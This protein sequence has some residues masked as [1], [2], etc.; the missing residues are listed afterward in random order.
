MAGIGVLRHLLVEGEDEVET[1]Y[2]FYPELWGRGYAMEVAI[3]CLER[4][5]GQVG[6]GSIVAV[7]HP[8]NRASQHVLRKV[9]MVYERKFPTLTVRRPP[10]FAFVAPA[11]TD[12]G[13]P[14]RSSLADSRSSLVGF[15]V[16]EA[17]RP[18][19][20]PFAVRAAL[21]TWLRGVIASFEQLDRPLL[22]GRGLRAGITY[23]EAL[24][25]RRSASAG[26]TACEEPRRGQ[27][28][29]AVHT[30]E[31]ARACRSRVNVAKVERLVQRGR[32]A[33]TGLAAFEA[34]DESRT[35]CYLVRARRDGAGAEVREAV[36]C[37]RRSSGRTSRAGP[38]ATAV[39][40]PSGS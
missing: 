29:G 8:D 5:F 10:S 12:A 32:M 19:R 11:G 6:L 24:E 7:T 22:Q 3:A 38:P 30:E 18:H 9:G 28:H 4:G 40:A 26:S 39:S 37:R 21:A 1:G 34:R 31:A 16:P 33:P 25:R 13:A 2:G 20:V 23:L 14:S 17:C 36:P 35:G 27:L 15:P